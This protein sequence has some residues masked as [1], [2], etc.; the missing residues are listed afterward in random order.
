MAKRTCSIDG[1][2]KAHDA[3]GWCKSHYARWREYGHPLAGGRPRDEPPKVTDYF[4]RGGDDDCWPW[5]SIKDRHGY[6]RWRVREMGIDTGAHRAV[7][8]HLVGP[9]PDGLVIDYLCRNRVCVNP[10]HMEPV[11]NAE[12]VRRGNAGSK[13]GWRR[14]FCKR[15]HLLAGDNVA[16]NGTNRLC[17]ECRNANARRK[18][19]EK[20]QRS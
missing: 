10:R 13:P 1:C 17:R 4:E 7:Y 18:Y 20:K 14:A 9:I 3:R 8:E 5:L 19:H 16:F 2:D 11:T 6:G 12:N 15:G